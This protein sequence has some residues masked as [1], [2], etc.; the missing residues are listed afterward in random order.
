MGPGSYNYS[1][2]ST[3]GNV[4]GGSFARTGRERGPFGKSALGSNIGPGQYGKSI[5]GSKGKSRGGW[6]FGKARRG[7]ELRGNGVPGPG[8]YS[9]QKAKV[10][11]VS[12]IGI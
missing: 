2:N 6:S 8:Q 11:F 5:T 7:T 12:K 9:K 3:W 4:N 10:K 1:R